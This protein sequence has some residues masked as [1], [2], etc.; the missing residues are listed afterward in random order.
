MAGETMTQ[1]QRVISPE[2]VP[3]SEKSGPLEFVGWAL[4]RFTHQ[5]MV[6]TTA[7]GMEGCALI[8]MFAKHQ[9]RLTVVYLDTCFFFPE[10]HALR[11]RL[12]ER[13]PTVTFVNRGADLTPEQ[14]AEVYGHELWK[15]NP[16]LCCK[17]RKVDPMADVMR[18]VD[19]WITGLRRSQSATRA[20]L[21]AVE[22]DWKF[23]VLK[24]SPLAN[25]DRQQ[26]WA[27][28][29]GNQVPYN[30]LH[31]KGYPT[32]GCTHCTKPVPGSK[33]GEYTRAGRWSG[34]DKTECGLHGGG[35]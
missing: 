10:T 26:V 6:M 23:Q 12:I 15:V 30:E 21:R 24:V 35:I 7:F 34:T 13:Y 22:W 32:V 14:Q 20:N 28:V 31:E 29:L 16:D 19:V 18:D 17:L 9:A 27:Y 25:W 2:R 4:D 8:D 3:V 1:S 5:R 33:I 11:D